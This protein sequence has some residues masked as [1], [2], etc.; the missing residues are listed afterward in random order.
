VKKYSDS[1]IYFIHDD[2]SEMQ[3]ILAPTDSKMQQFIHKEN[4]TEMQYI[5]SNGRMD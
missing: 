5:L 3:F 4:T 2:D 1:E